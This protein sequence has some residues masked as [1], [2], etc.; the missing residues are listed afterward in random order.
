MGTIILITSVQMSIR[1]WTKFILDSGLKAD[2]GITDFTFANLEGVLQH[3][4]GMD[5]WRV[6]RVLAWV[7]GA[8]GEQRGTVP[9]WIL[10]LVRADYVC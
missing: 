10:F 7:N 1:N 3:E 6:G 8:L 5:S 4:L 2:N 9:K